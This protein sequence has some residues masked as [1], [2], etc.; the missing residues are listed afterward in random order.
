MSGSEE[1]VLLPHERQQ[2]VILF[3]EVADSGGNGYWGELIRNSLSRAI[4]HAP[5][6]PG[7]A[8]AYAGAA[9]WGE[10]AS[11]RYRSDNRCTHH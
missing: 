7:D 1:L 8:F 9:L 6:C 5:G 11:D 10:S 3:L 2:L 4:H